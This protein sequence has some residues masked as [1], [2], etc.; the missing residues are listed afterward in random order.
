MLGI[1]FSWFPTCCLVLPIN[2]KPRQ[3]QVLG[4]QS[5]SVTQPPKDTGTVLGVIE[6]DPVNYF[7]C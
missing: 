4:I 5:V 6:R 2:A 3:L 1:Q 7:R